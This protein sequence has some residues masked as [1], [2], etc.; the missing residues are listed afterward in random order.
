MT[1]TSRIVITRPADPLSAE[2]AQRRAD[3]LQRLND[4]SGRTRSETSRRANLMDLARL[5][6]I[7]EEASV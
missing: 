4:T 1:R 2:I 6:K 7:V 3:R 5:L